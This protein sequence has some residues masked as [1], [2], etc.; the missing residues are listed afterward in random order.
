MD[1]KEGWEKKALIGL[2]GVV[3][4]IIIYA[5][6]APFSGTPDTNVSTNQA[7]PAQVVPVPFTQ[8]AAINSTSNNS[9]TTNGTLT[10]DQA[11]NITL[12]ANQGYTAGSI[13]RSNLVINGI[14]YPVWIVSITNSTTSKTVYVDAA[15][16]KIIQ[17]T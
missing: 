13:T 5:Y 14:V 9:S 3:F 12:S 10:A 6:V 1:L 16:G 15:S 11:R 7:V 17:T 2:G 8:P 4:L